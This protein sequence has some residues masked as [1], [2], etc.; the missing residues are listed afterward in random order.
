MPDT[1][2]TEQT[3]DPRTGPAPSKATE[4]GEPT[5]ESSKTHQDQIEEGPTQAGDSPKV[6]LETGAVSDTVAHPDSDYSQEQL[7]DLAWGLRKAAPY[8]LGADVRS[9]ESSKTVAKVVLETLSAVGFS[10]PEMSEETRNEKEE[11]EDPEKANKAAEKSMRKAQAEE[12][13]HKE[14]QEGQEGQ[15]GWEGSTRDKDREESSAQER[16]SSSSSSSSQ[17]KSSQSTSSSSKSPTSKSTG[18]S[19]TSSTSASSETTSKNS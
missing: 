4:G 16:S 6:S 13:R 15:E 11:S 10:F 12:K 7:D 19:G 17:P 1:D 18:S 14:E 5:P 8:F 2:T 3:S 9:D